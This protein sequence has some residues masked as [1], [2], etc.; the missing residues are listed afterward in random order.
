MFKFFCFSFSLSGSVWWPLASTSYG[1][2]A[3]ASIIGISD[4][5]VIIELPVEMI[6]CNYCLRRRCR[7]FF[8]NA[9]VPTANFGYNLLTFII[10][11]NNLI[12]ISLQVT[13]EVVRFIQVL[14][15]Y[16]FFREIPDEWILRIDIDVPFLWTRPLSSIM[17]WRCTTLKRTRRHAHELLIWMKSWA[18]WST[19]FRTKLVRLLRT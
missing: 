12:P 5:K 15:L 6:E 1:P 3:M 2:L 11:F 8:I 9:D 14:I 10:L 18:K 13:I 4:W 7:Y 17:I 16:W 19:S